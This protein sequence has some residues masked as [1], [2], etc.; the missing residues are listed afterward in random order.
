MHCQHAP[1]APCLPCAGSSTAMWTFMPHLPPPC[2]PC[3]RV[4]HCHVDLHAAS[5]MVMAFQVG[6]RGAD[7]WLLPTNLLNS[8][9]SQPDKCT[10]AA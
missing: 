3:C 7:N 8:G 2:L 1:P 4:F 5:G 9:G 10:C 6:E